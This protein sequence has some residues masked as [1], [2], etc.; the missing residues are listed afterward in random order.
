MG[1][2]EA[3]LTGQHLEQAVGVGRVRVEVGPVRQQGVR[4]AVDRPPL[5]AEIDVPVAADGRVARPLI[6]RKGDESAVLVVLCRQFVHMLPEGVV[7]LE[8]VR[9]VGGCVEEGLVAGEIEILRA[10][11]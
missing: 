3:V 10:P 4:G 5:L 2:D 9:L 11:W 7:D 8:V 6:A 1:V